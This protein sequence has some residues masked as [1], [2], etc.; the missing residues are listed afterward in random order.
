MNEAVT[1]TGAGNST[2]GRDTTV[3]TT[4]V[5]VAPSTDSAQSDA[6]SVSERSPDSE[7]APGAG[8]N[9]HSRSQSDTVS[10]L[11]TGWLGTSGGATQ[12][13]RTPLNV[14]TTSSAPSRTRRISAHPPQRHGIVGRRRVSRKWPPSSKIQWTVRPIRATIWTQLLHASNSAT[15]R[16]RLGALAPDQRTRPL[17]Q[18][19]LKGHPYASTPCCSSI[20]GR[21]SRH[22]DRDGLPRHTRTSPRD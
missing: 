13:T 7:A 4:R 9:G 22:A 2:W 5:I 6:R 3:V 16:T 14:I 12:I 17:R 8:C 20:P 1:V 19:S 18:P 15:V 11:A 21:R 10:T